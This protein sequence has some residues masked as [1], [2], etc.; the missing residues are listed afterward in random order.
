MT[1]LFIISAF[2]VCVAYGFTRSANQLVLKDSLAA[3]NTME[4][5]IIAGLMGY[6]ALGLATILLYIKI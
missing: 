4:L 2:C 1:I 6:L 5:A 3:Y